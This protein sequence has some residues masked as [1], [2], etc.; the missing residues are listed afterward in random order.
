[1]PLV[2]M[3]AQKSAGGGGIES[4]EYTSFTIS[5]GAGLN[6]PTSKKAKAIAF[7]YNN[8][9]IFYAVDGVNNNKLYA[10]N[11]DNGQT[12]TFGDNA[13][14]STSGISGSSRSCIACI[15]Y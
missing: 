5:A 10:N 2:K 3:D 9:Y 7:A 4:T 12:V 11:S 8:E 15:F 13:I 6:V 1:M 14:T